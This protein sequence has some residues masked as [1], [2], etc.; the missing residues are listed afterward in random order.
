VRYFLVLLV[1]LLGASPAAQSLRAKTT[2]EQ[3]TADA[4]RIII[5]SVA[6]VTVTTLTTDE[7]DQGIFSL[8]TLNVIRTIKG[9]STSTIVLTIPGGTSG[10]V[11]MRAPS[12]RIPAVGERLRVFVVPMGMTRFKVLNGHLGLVR[13][14]E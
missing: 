13:S 4:T 6:S 2:L 3:Q 11:T 5:G 9:A 10:G 1:A 14:L 8:V 12:E 7:G